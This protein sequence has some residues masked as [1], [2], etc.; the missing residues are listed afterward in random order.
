MCLPGKLYGIGMGPGDPELLTLKAVRIMNE[1]DVVFTAASS[2]NAYSLAVEIAKPYLSKSVKII[3]LAFPMT[4]DKTLTQ[5]A[6][7]R[8]ARQI[9]AV[10][11]LG[12]TACFLTLGDPTIY[13]TFGY[14]LKSLEIIMPEAD[15]ITIPGITSFNAAA[16]R[17]NHVLVEAEESLLITS[18]ACGGNQ[19]RSCTTNVQNV[20]MMKAYKNIHDINKALIEKG[21]DKRVAISKCSREEEEIFENTEDLETRDPNYWTL[22]LAG[23]TGSNN[24]LNGY[25]R[26][27]NV[28]P[29][30]ITTNINSLNVIK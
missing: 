2:K 25:E 11:K 23:K 14:V 10:L 15:I 5:E 12:K 6:W 7:D 8:N 4:F 13:S 19:L 28:Y 3:S 24:S 9:A 21:F 26:A 22:I 30:C 16:A 17:L 27:N 29:D 1:A 18:G 20:V